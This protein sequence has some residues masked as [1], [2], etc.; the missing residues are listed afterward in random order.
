M[1]EP[2]LLL[3]ALLQL[4]LLL[5]LLVEQLLL[6]MGR[7]AVDRIG[8]RANRAGWFRLAVVSVIRAFL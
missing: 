6:L 2:A 4:L 5:M 1:V 8:R 3:L 7:R